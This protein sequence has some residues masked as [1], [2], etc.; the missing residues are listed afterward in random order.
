[1]SAEADPSPEPRTGHVP[2]EEGQIL[3]PS[4]PLAVF[5][6]GGEEPIGGAAFAMFGA[7]YGAEFPQVLFVSIGI[8]NQT[9]V[10]AG[11]DG[12]GSFKGAEEARR[13]LV[14]TR[15]DLTSYLESARNLGLKADARVSVSVDAAEEI[16]RLS[17]E[18]SA[19]H[20]KAVYFLSKLVFSKPRWYHR[21]LHS[22]ISDAIR[23][24]LEKRGRPVTVLPVVVSL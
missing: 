20:P 1:M 16:E 11:V 23:K 22:S 15:E 18:I 12:T 19:E 5:L 24:R 2:D 10:D 3:D 6:V 8:M 21:W 7:R 9:V 13:L 17:D 14:K 4:R